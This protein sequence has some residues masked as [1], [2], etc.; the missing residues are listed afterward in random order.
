MLH[1][2]GHS[3][4][5]GQVIRSQEDDIH[6]L[7]SEDIVDRLHSG[8]ALDVNDHHGFLVG[9]FGHALA[10]GAIIAGSEENGET[11]QPE[12][13]VVGS[14]DGALGVGPSTAPAAPECRRPRYR[15]RAARG[16]AHW[17]GFG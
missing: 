15:E 1:L 12:R 11:S 10:A 4:R 6:T 7:D 8:A 9:P 5:L 16:S 3:Y 17:Q 2:P 13:S 14:L